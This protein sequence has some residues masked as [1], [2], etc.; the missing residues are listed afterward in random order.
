MLLLKIQLFIV[1][2]PFLRINNW[3]N[4]RCSLCALIQQFHAIP[5]GSNLSCIYIYIYPI[6]YS[7]SYSSP[8]TRTSTRWR[9]QLRSLRHVMQRRVAIGVGHQDAAGLTLKQQ[10][11]QLHLESSRVVRG[12]LSFRPEEFLEDSKQNMAISGTQSP[13]SAWLGS[14]SFLSHSVRA[15][16]CQ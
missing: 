8:M 14:S 2:Y 11:Q 16:H 10:T 6:E 4:S 5:D 9:L 3:I 7:P 1:L 15:M 12:D 13:V